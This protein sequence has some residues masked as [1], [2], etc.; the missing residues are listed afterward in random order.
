MKFDY[1]EDTDTLYIELSHRPSVES[2]EVGPDVVIDLDAEHNVVGI[3]IERASQKVD[4]SNLSF[5]RLPFQRSQEQT[6]S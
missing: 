1:F 6:R 4:L 5:A 2:D 3:E